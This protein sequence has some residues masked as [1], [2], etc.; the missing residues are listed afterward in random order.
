[1]SNIKLFFVAITTLIIFPLM[2]AFAIIAGGCGTAC[3]NSGDVTLPLQ[4]TFQDFLPYLWR[5][6]LL[7]MT[8]Y[9]SGYVLGRLVQKEKI[10]P[11][12][13]RKLVC[14]LTFAVSYI[15]SLSTPAYGSF[16]TCMLVAFGCVIILLM[17]G[18][19]AKPFRDN[20]PALRTIFSSINRP[21][22][23][24]YTLTWLATEVII[25]S[26]VIIIF[27]PLIHFFSKNIL[28][29]QSILYGVMLIPIFASGIGDA[30]AEIV[31]KKWGRH[32][33]QTRSIFGN[34]VYTRS[35]EGSSMVFLTTI[36][37]GLVVAMQFS[38]H[39][40][41]FFWK[42]FILLPITLTLAEAKS[43][44]TWDNP[45]LYFTGYVT[46]ILCLL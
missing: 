28:I 25:T 31:G 9:L 15:N 20:F 18:S 43:P 19:L 14:L 16:I 32:H 3:L 8:F 30:L 1:M 17:L 39:M 34:R 7:V 23:E 38:F 24:P 41:V 11:S 35:L 10:S 40:P 44:H 36:I 33:Y 29:D 26:L 4:N 46:I 2:P 21:E 6:L 12:F 42:A 5:Q 13:S 27:I 22:D 37:T 45:L